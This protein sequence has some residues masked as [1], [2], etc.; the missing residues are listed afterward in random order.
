MSMELQ[1]IA[2]RLR[3]ISAELNDL[4]VTMRDASVTV[5]MFSQALE[6]ENMGMLMEMFADGTEEEA[7]RGE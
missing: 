6:V 7:C 1:N 2:N 3:S 5:H 4:G